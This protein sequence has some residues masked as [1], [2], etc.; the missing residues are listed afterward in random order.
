MVVSTPPAALGASDGAARAVAASAE[1]IHIEE[2]MMI[3][4]EES[5]RLRL[6][7]EMSIEVTIRNRK[8]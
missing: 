7:E 1:D 2:I 5:C 6:G 3:C 8:L 4:V